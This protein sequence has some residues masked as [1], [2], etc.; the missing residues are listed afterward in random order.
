MP[1]EMYVQN[2]NGGHVPV[3]ITLGAMINEQES[4]TGY[5]LVL[6]RRDVPAV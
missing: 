2:G 1:D 5:V 3:T 6:Q 4:V